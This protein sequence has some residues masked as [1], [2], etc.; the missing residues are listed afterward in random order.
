MICKTHILADTVLK[1][2]HFIIFL[3]YFIFFRK[4]KSNHKRMNPVEKKQNI[5]IIFYRTLLIFLETLF[6]IL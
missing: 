2:L 3:G 6:S 4:Q 5:Y 1:T